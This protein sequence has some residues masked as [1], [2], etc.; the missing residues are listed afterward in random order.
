VGCG[1][2]ISTFSSIFLGWPIAYV[3]MGKFKQEKSKL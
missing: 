3:L 1:V 2:I